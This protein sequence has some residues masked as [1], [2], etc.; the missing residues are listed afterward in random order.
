[1]HFLA[2][3]EETEFWTKWVMVLFY[4]RYLFPECI[5]CFV[6]CGLPRIGSDLESIG[7]YHFQ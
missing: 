6:V 5:F 2:C 4:V 1:M 3:K 7:L